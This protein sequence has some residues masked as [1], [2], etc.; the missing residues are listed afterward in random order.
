MLNVSFRSTE[1]QTPNTAPSQADKLIT[2][3]LAQVLGMVDVKVLD[4]LIVGGS[5][6]YSFAEHGLI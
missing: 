4:H 6:I 1:R 2:E 5:D 3:R